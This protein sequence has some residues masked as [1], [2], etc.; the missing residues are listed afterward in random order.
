MQELLVGEVVRRKRIEMGLT[1]EEL[2]EGICEAFTISRIE[3]GKQPPSRSTADALLQRLGVSDSRYY[4]AFQSNIYENSAEDIE[5]EYQILILQ[6]EIARFCDIERELTDL[7]KQAVRSGL[8]SKC[9]STISAFVWS[10]ALVSS[11]T[12]RSWHP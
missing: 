9:Y 8:A 12:R 3:N 6:E 7:D 10:K 1:Q 5:R 4:F 11:S 2:C